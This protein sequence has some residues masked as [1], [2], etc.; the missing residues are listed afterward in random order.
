MYC[1][2]A[3]AHCFTVITGPLCRRYSGTQQ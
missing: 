2:I 3:A 1:T